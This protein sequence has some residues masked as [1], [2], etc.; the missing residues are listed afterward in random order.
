MNRTYEPASEIEVLNTDAPNKGL[1][2]LL[3]IRHVPF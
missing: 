2:A 3:K 1:E